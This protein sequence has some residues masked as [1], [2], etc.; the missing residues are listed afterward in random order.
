MNQEDLT[1]WEI[2]GT[3]LVLDIDDIGDLERYERAFKQMG[4]AAKQI[5]KDGT[6]SEITRAYCT[7]FYNMYDCIFGDGTAE[8]IH[9]KK[10][11]A[12]ECEPYLTSDY[13]KML[14]EPE[15]LIGGLKVSLSLFSSKR[16]F[17]SSSNSYSECSNIEFWK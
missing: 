3:T 1:K 8:K 6:A 12:A 4:E 15:Y 2:N 10:Y 14:E 7:T 5:P 17:N 13:R 9:K 11:S 16:H